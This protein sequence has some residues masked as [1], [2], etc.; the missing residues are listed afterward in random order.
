MATL[1]KSAHPALAACL[2]ALE[3]HPGA[4]VKALREELPAIKEVIIYSA[5]ATLM[6]EGKVRM[7]GQPRSRNN[8]YVLV[9]EGEQKA[10]AQAAAK[11]VKATAAAKVAKHQKATAPAAKPVA[12]AKATK[13]KPAAKPTAV[14][15]KPSPAA[16]AKKLV[17]TPK[18]N[19]K[20][21]TKVAK[22]AKLHP[23]PASGEQALDQLVDALVTAVMPRLREKLKAKLKGESSA[24]VE[25][26]LA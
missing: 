14:K 9:P 13:T 19:A 12:P 8:G 21:A 18:P 17:Q 25:S 4:A 23:A 7:T 2:S 15:S 16:V 10:A 20:P 22:L 1:L 6:H 24:M 3:R 5:L 11:A 26:L